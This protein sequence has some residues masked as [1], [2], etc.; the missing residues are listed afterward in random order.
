MSRAT[1]LILGT[2]VT[3]VMIAATAFFSSWPTYR[4]LPEGV[5]VV[6]LSFSHGGARNCRNRTES[7]LAKLPPSLRK[8]EICERKR[9]PVY[10]EM[11]IDSESVYRASLPPSGIAR[12]G[13]SRVYERFELPA[14][15]YEIAVRLRDTSQTE[16]FDDVAVHRL[17]LSAGQSF[18]ID[19]RRTAGG[20][21]FH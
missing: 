14:G 17:S 12:D 2:I 1:H 15:D 11:D 20:F 21:I 16:G 6:T 5:G 10:L 8:T 7:E 19:F 13:P 9:Q 3:T 18:V 4:A